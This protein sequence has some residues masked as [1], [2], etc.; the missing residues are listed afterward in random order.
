MKIALIIRRLNVRGGAQRQALALAQELKKRGHDILLY[1]AEGGWEASYPELL[2]GLS[3]AA[4]T[5]PH[6]M[7]RDFD[8]LNPHDRW[9]HA[10]ACAYKKK[11][12]AV[13]SI[14]MMNDLPT[15]WFSLFR[16]SECRGE[17]L[18]LFKEYGARIFDFFTFRRDIRCQDAIAV[19]D[20]RDAAWLKRFFGKDAVVVRSGVDSTR[21]EFRARTMP[22][23]KKLSILLTG[24]LLPHRRFE[25]LIDA[26]AILQ[27]DGYS[28]L[29]DIIGDES[30]NSAYAK[31]LKDRVQAL[32]LSSAIR[33]LGKVSEGDLLTHYSSHD[34]FVFPNHLQS[35]GLAVFEAMATGMPVIVSKTAGPS[36]VL[37]DGENALLVEPKSPQSIAEALRHL[38]ESSELFQKLSKNGRMFVEKNMS[39]ETYADTMLELFNKALSHYVISH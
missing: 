14:W 23:G 37:T 9:A 8:I 4:I 16:E 11:V 1:V 39:W 6:D 13:P 36:E 18:S 29:V 38:A 32:N 34:I 19:L 10:I 12:R 21:S 15:R 28:I 7:A 25:D 30:Q 24:I 33:F 27:K 5:S 2:Q 22:T 26:V 35:W 3:I 31:R 17:K 20:N